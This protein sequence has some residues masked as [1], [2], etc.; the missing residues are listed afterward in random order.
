MT[1]ELVETLSDRQLEAVFAHEVGHGVHRH[2][3]WYLAAFFGG[4]FLATGLAVAWTSFMPAHLA[5]FAGENT[6]SVLGMVLLMGMLT[7]GFPLI[8]H[9]FEHQADWFACRHMARSVQPGETTRSR[10][11]EDRWSLCPRFGETG[12]QGDAGSIQGG[13]VSQCRHRCARA[14]GRLAAG[15]SALAAP[16]RPPQVSPA[17][18]RSVPPRTN[19]AGRGGICTASSQDVADLAAGVYRRAL[20]RR[21]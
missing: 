6:A 2:L 21:R 16:I 13:A 14:A 12:G 19:S 15:A 9:R 7:L 8:S 4:S 17:T 5:N 11:C 1:D 3:W 10:W 18:P 20:A